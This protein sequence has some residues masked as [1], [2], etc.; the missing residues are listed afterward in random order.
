MTKNNKQNTNKFENFKN[1][2][3]KNKTDL[4][5]KHF[6]I[7]LQLNLVNYVLLYKL[8]KYP[9]IIELDN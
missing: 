4:K 7:I 8:V 6:E 5:F 1:S 9:T 2:K 3:I